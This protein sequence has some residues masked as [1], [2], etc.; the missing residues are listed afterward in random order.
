MIYTLR[1]ALFSVFLLL[2]ATVSVLGQDEAK[3]SK[4]AAYTRVINERAAKIV[5]TLGITDVPTSSRVQQ[6]IVQQYRDLNAIHEGRK[7]AVKRLS[8]TTS[9]ETLETERNRVETETNSKLE[10]L[11]KEYVAALARELTAMQVDQVR[12]GMTYGVLPITYKGYQ[13]MLPDLTDAQKTQILS[14]LTE[15]RE[16]AMDVG[17]SEGKHAVFGKYK[18]KINNYLSAAGIDMKK[19]GKEWEERIAKEAKK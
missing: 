11:H 4:E 6:T 17:T 1:N 7:E 14:W 9:K 12:D 2:F 3:E 16:R 15:A 19:A 18:G 5:A 10:K 13:A 8:E